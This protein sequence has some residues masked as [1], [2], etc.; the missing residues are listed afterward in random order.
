MAKQL[1]QPEDQQ[2]WSK[3]DSYK[4]VRLRL[5]Y[6]SYITSGL[7]TLAVVIFLITNKPNMAL[8][9]SAVIM[10]FYFSAFRAAPG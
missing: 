7:A 9:R 3:N 6:G 5:I 1:E 4:T 8:N 2:V 10:R